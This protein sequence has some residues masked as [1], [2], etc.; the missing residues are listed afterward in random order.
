M[1]VGAVGGTGGCQ[2][3]LGR[4]FRETVIRYIFG[5]VNI[6]FHYRDCVDQR[7]MRTLAQ[8]TH[9]VAIQEILGEL[10]PVE[11]KLAPTVLN[12]A[13]DP[14]LLRT[15]PKVAVVGSRKATYEGLE[16]ASKVAEAL[17][18]LGATVVSGLAVG[19]DTT[20]HQAAIRAG[21]QTFAVIG[22]GLDRAYPR[23]NRDLQR[24]LAQHFAVVSQF[25]SGTPPSRRN[26]PQ[27]NRTMALLSDA[28][29][30]VEAGET[31]G[32][33]NQGWEA[34][35]L[36]RTVLLSEAVAHN[37]ALSW[38]AEMQRYG[39]EVLPRALLTEMLSE[40]PWV[41]AAGEALF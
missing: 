9:T 30:I 4:G 36:G 24:Y 27:R 28:L 19:I 25:P 32:T 7:L 16:S 3:E 6:P 20:A 33:I 31:S 39:A 10:T 13:G 11:R 1:D 37:P 38:P 2:G 29:V 26:F 40:L 35:R 21:G 15:S 17:V 8:M 5:N 14:A 22:T 23:E 34:L 18:E 41:T 12:V